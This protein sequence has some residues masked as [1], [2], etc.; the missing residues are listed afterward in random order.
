[1]AG[2]C[3]ATWRAAARADQE[4]L[5]G[6]L[7]V[8]R[9][10]LHGI[11]VLDDYSTVACSSHKDWYL[12]RALNVRSSNINFVSGPNGSGKSAILQAIQLVWPHD[13]L[14]SAVS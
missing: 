9:A 2:C 12:K 11:L 6:K 3:A 5:D 10:L 14:R 4:H 8:P 13:V 7:H 1:M